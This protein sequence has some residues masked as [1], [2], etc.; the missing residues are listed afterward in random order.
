MANIKSSNVNHSQNNWS[1]R[2]FN[3]RTYYY[4]LH[5]C[6]DGYAGKLLEIFD[7]IVLIDSIVY[8]VIRSIL[9]ENL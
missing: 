6:R 8:V 7:V 2:K 9:F 3:F 1:F 5:I 4:Y